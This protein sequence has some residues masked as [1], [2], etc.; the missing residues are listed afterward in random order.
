MVCPAN[1][2]AAAAAVRAPGNTVMTGGPVVGGKVPIGSLDGSSEDGFE[3][4]GRGG[5]EEAVG[6]ALPCAATWC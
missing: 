5:V 1:G 3:G 4:D 6:D 2:T